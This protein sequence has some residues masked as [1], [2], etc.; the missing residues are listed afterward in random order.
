MISFIRVCCCTCRYLSAYP[1]GSND[2]LSLFLEVD[3]SGLL[4]IGWRRHTKFSFTVLNQR[5][6]KLSR[7]HGKWISNSSAYFF[8]PKIE[9]FR[10]ATMYAIFFFYSTELLVLI[11]SL[12][13][14]KR[15]EIQ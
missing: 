2:H 11:N 12:L 3:N 6:K 7:K 8:I 5:S 14:I 1:K 13:S 9:E 10:F 4:P 15:V